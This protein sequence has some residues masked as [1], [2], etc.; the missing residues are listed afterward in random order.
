VGLTAIEG[1]IR[2]APG[3]LHKFYDVLETGKREPDDLASRIKALKGRMNELEGQQ[4]K[5]SS[6]TEYVTYSVAHTVLWQ[7]KGSATQYGKIYVQEL[8]VYARS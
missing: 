6:Q 1:Q 2:D 4:R 7:A 3:R 8:R 5:L